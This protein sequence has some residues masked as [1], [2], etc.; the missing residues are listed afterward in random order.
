LNTPGPPVGFNK[1]QQHL[2]IIIIII[3]IIGIIPG[4]QLSCM[5]HN[6]GRNRWGKRQRFLSAR[7]AVMKHPN[8]WAGVHGA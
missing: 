1:Q 5:E 7:I 6:P 3:I 8:G 2:I 4:F